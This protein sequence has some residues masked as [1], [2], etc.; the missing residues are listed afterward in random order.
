MGDLPGALASHRAGVMIR[1]RR[2]LLEL[3]EDRYAL[4]ST[5]VTSQLALPAGMLYLP[6]RA[7][8]IDWIKINSVRRRIGVMMA[9]RCAPSD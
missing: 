7:A 3:V 9:A 6:R 8:H 4:R 1:E 2:D 5:L